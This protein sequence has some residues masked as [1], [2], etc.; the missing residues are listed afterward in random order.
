MLPPVFY[1]KL[2]LLPHIIAIMDSPPVADDSSGLAS[3]IGALSLSAPPAADRAG[4]PSAA[5]ALPS[6]DRGFVNVSEYRGSDFKGPLP[7]SLASFGSGTVLRRRSNS[8]RLE[9]FKQVCTSMLPPEP[10][11]EPEPE[12]PKPAKKKKTKRKNNKKEKGKKVAAGPE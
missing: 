4:R 1:L 11:P 8:L 5:D 6:A 3:D 7:T 12:P 2:S 9:Q 10:A